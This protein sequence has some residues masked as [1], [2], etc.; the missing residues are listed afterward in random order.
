MHLASQGSPVHRCSI[1]HSQR[2]RALLHADVELQ[3]RGAHR[4]SHSGLAQG[5]AIDQRVV[6]PT[7][8]GALPVQ[9][10]R[11]PRL[12]GFVRPTTGGLE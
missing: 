7:F 3:R 1:R 2:A 11:A 8:G 12:R 5:A 6:A 10:G 4:P 9:R